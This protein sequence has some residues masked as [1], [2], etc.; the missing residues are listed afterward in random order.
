MDFQSPQLQP[1]RAM[2]LHGTQPHTATWIA[3]GPLREE[4][5][6][7]DVRDIRRASCR[8]GKKPGR[9]THGQQRN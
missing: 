5:E 2:A 4:Q 1:P 8:L 6:D 7:G 9:S 3:E